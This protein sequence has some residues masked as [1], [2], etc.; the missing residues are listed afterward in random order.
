MRSITTIARSLASLTAALALLAGAIAAQDAHA[1]SSGRA[2]HSSKRVVDLPISFAVHNTNRSKVICP[3]DGAAYVV[4]GHLVAPR[5]ELAPAHSADRAV[6]I[7]M[8]G[9]TNG[10]Q[11]VWR[12]R[13][14]GYNWARGMAKAGHVSVTFDRLGYG[15]SGIPDGMQV[16]AGSEADVTHQMV[17]ALRS[18]DYTVARRAAPRFRKVALAGVSGGGV[19]AQAEAYS[20]QD[21]DA[22]IELATTFDQG[23]STA[24]TVDLVANPD[25]MIPTCAR[26]GDP[27]YPDGHGPRNYAYLV[28]QR[29]DL[30]FY[31]ADPATVATFARGWEREPCSTGLSLVPVL[32]A[33]ALYM[34]DIT[35]PV[36]IAMGDHDAIFPPPSGERQR[37]LYTGSSDTTLVTLPDTGHAIPLERTAPLARAAVSDWLRDHGF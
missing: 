30:L 17:T 36:L 16:C 35:V 13:V 18:G 15:T 29:L 7:Y 2:R 21:I 11:V 22:L 31:N 14:P 3:S 6:T 32:V 19:A 26:G 28:K 9:S 12:S 20:F 33:D 8:H 5:A 25:P 27:K 10:E 23:F 4:R 34:R 1:A 37:A 24:F